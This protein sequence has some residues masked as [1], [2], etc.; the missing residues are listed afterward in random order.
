MDMSPCP[1]YRWRHRSPVRTLHDLP[2]IS[3]ATWQQR[4]NWNPGHP[5]PRH[6]TGTIPSFPAQVRVQTRVSWG[7]K[8]Q[9]GET[10]HQQRKA[11][12]LRVLLAGGGGQ[13]WRAPTVWLSQERNPR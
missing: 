9:A 13:L 3:C 1:F 12:L 10:V 4:K 2:S 11:D 6:R 8:I 7:R 5:T